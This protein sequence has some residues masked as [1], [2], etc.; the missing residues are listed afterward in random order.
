MT[1][2]ESHTFDK[3]LQQNIS[4][5]YE[6]KN[7]W[8]YAR[9]AINNSV[10]GDL[11]ELGNEPANLKCSTVPYTIIGTI[12]LF[13]DKWA[14][15]STDDTNCEIGLF[16]E[17][18]CSYKTIVNDPC[19]NLKKSN[20]IT[21]ISKANTDC[22]WQIYWQDALNPD[23][24]MCIGDP[25]DWPTV[26]LPN[27]PCVPFNCNP[28]TVS[29][30]PNN[31][32][33]SCVVCEP[34]PALGLDCD[35]IRLASLVDQPCIKVTKGPSGGELINGS[36]YVVIAYLIDGER[37]TDYSLPSNVQPLF[38]HD[39]V[40]GSILITIES[41]D[42]NH[43]SEF[44]LVLVSTINQQT[45][46]KRVGTYS[47][48]QQTINIDIVNPRWE[49][50]PLS[51]ISQRNPVVERTE[52]I[53]ENNDYAMRI[54]TYDKFDFNYQPKANLIR[55]KWQ[56]VQYPA[57][58]YEKGGN[59]TQ[60]MR[61]EVY[62]FFIRW[63]YNTGDRSSS[64]HIP[65]RPPTTFLTTNGPYLED[66]VY[67]V[68]NG[69]PNNI[70][71]VQSS[72]TQNPYV[73]Q[74]FNT[75]TYTPN[76]SYPQN[77]P[78]GGVLLYEG[79]MGYWQS[80]E[81]YP[82]DNPV[83]WNSFPGNPTDPNNLCGKAIRHHKFPEDSLQS[84]PSFVS[85]YTLR[86]ANAGQNIRLMGVKFYNIEY[87]TDNNGAPI[88]GVVGYEILR[89]TREGNKSVIAKGMLNNLG[90]Y[91]IPDTVNTTKEG[92]YPNYPYNQVKSAD[93]FLYKS[94]TSGCRP[95][96]DGIDTF[97]QE[98]HTFHGPDTQFKNPFLSMEELKV[99][100]E[101][102]STGD[103]IDSGV[104]GKFYLAENHPRF[105]LINDL[106]LVTAV[107]SGFGLGIKA[108]GG[109][110]R[111]VLTGISSNSSAWA[112]AAGTGGTLPVQPGGTASGAYNTSQ[113]LTTGVNYSGGLAASLLSGT[114]TDPYV[115]ALNAL[116]ITGGTVPGTFGGGVN[117]ELEDT[118]L[119]QTPKWLNTIANSFPTF[120]YYFSQGVDTIFEFI[121]NIVAYQNYA[122][123]YRSHA[124]YNYWDQPTPSNR[125]RIINDMVYLSPHIQEFYSQSTGRLY[126]V[127]NLYRGR[128]VLLDLAV[129]PTQPHGLEFPVNTDT[130]KQTVG[131]AIDGGYLADSTAAITLWNEDVV[132]APFIK[133]PT[134]VSHYVAL[135]QQ[136]INQYGQIDG[137]IQVPTNLCM[138][139]VNTNTQFYNSPVV[140]GG[141]T[142]V[143]RYTEKNTM[144]FFYEW[145]YGQDDGYEFNYN[146]KKN[147]PFPTYWV[148]S[149]KYDIFQ[150]IQSIYNSFS[151]PSVSIVPPSISGGGFDADQ[152]LV[153]SRTRVLD[154]PIG[155]CVAGP[156]GSILNSFTPYGVVGAWFYLFNSGVRDFFVE[157]EVNCALRDWN[158]LP[159]QRHYDPYK[160]T[161]LNA[162]FD[163]RIIKS[164]N[165]F[166][167]DYS[168]SI[169]KL[170]N[171]Y[172][173]WGNTQDRDY[174]PDI[175]EKCYV[176]RPN[177][178]I[179]SMPDD[180]SVYPTNNYKD[181]KSRPSSIKALGKTGALIF[182]Y[183]ESPLRL[184]GVDS[185]QTGAGNEVVL[186]DGGL[187]A[188]DAQNINNSEKAYE[189]A[190]CQSKFGVANTPMGLY[191]ISQNQGKIFV[192]NQGPMEMS[193]QDIRWWLALYLPYRLTQDFPDFELTDNP[194]IGIGCQTVYN[195]MDGLL[196]F[197]KKDFRLKKDLQDTVTY[198]KDDIFLVNNLFEIRLGDKRY[199]D[200]ASWTLS[201]DPKIKSWI[202]WHDWHP[203]L[204]MPGKKVFCTTKTLGGE[205]GIWR[206]ND[207]SDLYCNFYG[208]DYPFEFEFRIHSGQTVQI[209]K[210]I[211]YIMEVYKYAPNETDRFHVLDFNFDEAVVY[212][213]EQVSG[214][215]KLSI[216]P[217]NNAPEIVKYPK[218]NTNSIDILYSKVENKYRFDQFW[219]ITDDRGE[220]TTAQR[221]I[222]LTEENGYKKSLNPVNLNYQKPPFQRKKFRHYQV[223]VFL[224][225]KVSGDKKML[226]MIHN[227][228][229]QISPR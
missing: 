30:D 202:S 208:F 23:R 58:Y 204:V 25:N 70:E 51:D 225:R 10:S 88:P 67:N 93:P 74:V 15:M 104:D 140:F 7:T 71:F 89:G 143:T 137:I 87:P 210:S 222:W 165:Y 31:P 38:E 138:Q 212:N 17:E 27:W 73:F 145:L 37:V 107:I 228:K 100:G 180:W 29:T 57:D 167:Y 64:Y 139:A 153:P 152:W 28:T 141:D 16:E 109:S 90:V 178:I 174:D 26:Q 220:F 163:I 126:S 183:N 54:G 135:K 172:V 161:D 2:N 22:T 184:P 155:D 188:R 33:F 134:A 86:Y 170:Y 218:V 105:K 198:I 49:D 191:W 13:A 179:Y 3:S 217:K 40:A 84:G 122:L 199:F 43:F 97:H 47:V 160:Y 6:P 209:L 168:L 207:R 119:S 108:A 112:T 128:C 32:Q 20:L 9:N 166:K 195:N 189:Y 121:R 66:A 206:H 103:V 114:G 194:V 223:S 227:I 1:P 213:T 82:S 129:P 69:D 187:F 221:M 4:N 44:E 229:T 14:I 154:R 110:R 185:L 46:A 150:V 113:L 81:R 35:A 59:V 116:G 158:D 162:L 56:C 159:E 75:A 175:A 85:N 224:S 157:S 123:V 120:L 41:I 68:N 133:K 83:V 65:G 77:L 211:E 147:V 96:P 226:V 200:D 182:F 80:T 45:V 216:T 52:G 192:F 164:G 124:F 72:N 215:L 48:Q 131:T 53:Y 125:R 5:F 99:Y 197:T 92:L 39:A 205:G 169:S 193:S 21:G 50:V 95:A 127:N 18:R 118:A 190:S 144:P 214:L 101:V 79:D 62:S 148:D 24:S 78:D 177:R 146:T 42:T 19:L 136:L 61:D 203:E 63:V 151:L 115:T 201:Y 117:T 132:T 130:S 171:N 94:Q 173:S 91:Q 176:Y 219:D 156:L 142:Y 12:Y 149:N 196:Y 34:D 186:G 55:A 181:F 102:V 76:A 60:Y 36:Y 8:T 11:G 98:V 106:A 111:I